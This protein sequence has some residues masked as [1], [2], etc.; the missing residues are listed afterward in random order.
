MSCPYLL[1]LHKL[2][3]GAV[4]DNILAKDGGGER[5]VDLLRVDVLDLSVQDEVVALGVEHD[6]HLATEK[7]KSEDIS[8]LRLC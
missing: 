3:V 8:V 1:L 5:C 7:D 4:V 6:G 2:R